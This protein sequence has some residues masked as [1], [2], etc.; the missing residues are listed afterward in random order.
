[1]SSPRTALFATALASAIVL[2]APAAYASTIYPPTGSCS[3]SPATASPGGTVVLSCQAGTFS[4]DEQVTIT[5]S[6]E[7]GAGATIGQ[8]KTAVSTASGTAASAADGSLPAV[9]ITLP[10]N[11][12]GTY[13]IAAFSTTS[14]G[15]TAALTVTGATGVLSLTGV[16]S[17]TTIALVIGGGAV[18][19]AGIALLVGVLLRRRSRS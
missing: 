14:A 9:D 16:D 5:V 17:G 18:L 1:M 8:I 12:S 2:S 13:N 15:G 10:S 3:V 11:A 6:G 7:N 4:A 19:L